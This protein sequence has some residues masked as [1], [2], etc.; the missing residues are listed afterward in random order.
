MIK[1]D[2][3][4]H[5]AHSDDSDESMEAVIEE[6]VNKGMDAICFTE[7]MD[8]DFPEREGCF[9]FL[10][11]TEAY[12]RHF[13]ECREKYKNK[14]KLLFGVEYGMQPHL[15][16][17]CS[18]YISEWP[19]DLVIGSQHTVN[20]KDPYYSDF[21]EGRSE[22]EA[23]LEY[24]EALLDSVRNFKDVDVFGHLDYVVRYGPERDL[25]YSY[26]EYADI[27]DEILK[28]VIESGKGIEL[29]SGG[30]SNHL[31]HPNPREDVLLRYRELGGEIL[32]VG[33]DA[34][35]KERLAGDF[36][37]LEAVIKQ[38]GFRYITIFE[39]KKPGF[40]KI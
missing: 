23:Y 17:R 5:S 8:M 27:L 10:L 25:H 4:V 9:S 6:A 33:S 35:V 12:R 20:G 7:H 26:R 22:R 3:H 2:L 36:D 40:I 15:T 29:N 16:E 14:I 1:V 28:A 21:Y 24:F 31:S 38:A 11:D 30:Y 32:T 19:F 18:S 13:E 39:A 37:R 34:H